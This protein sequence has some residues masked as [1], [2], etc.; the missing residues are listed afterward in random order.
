MATT[1]GDLVTFCEHGGWLGRDATS[2]AQLRLWIDDTIQWLGRVRRWPDYEESTYI[3]LLAPY[4]TGT[5]TVTEASTTVLGESP[6]DVTD[7]M[8]GQEFYCA[9]E[10]GKLYQ[11]AS[12]SSGANTLTLEN[13]YTGD[14]G[15]EQDF[16][17]R[18]VRYAAPTDWGQAGVLYLPDGRELT[19]SNLSFHDW[20]QARITH[21]GTASWPSDIVYQK[22]SG[23]GYFF[24]HP[25]PSAASSVR[26]TYWAAPAALTSDSDVTDWPDDLMSLLHTVLKK[27]M[28]TDLP[29]PTFFSMMASELRDDLDAAMRSR[30]ALGPMQIHPPGVEGGIGP[31]LQSIRALFNFPDA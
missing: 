26:G 14:D 15:S 11:I 7:A 17:I 28:S 12:V 31:G 16:S 23:T 24:V 30:G 6:M 21:Q 9:D 2:V 10:P 1:L 8:A 25:A 3:D 4:T 29:N 13:A 5:V 22:V 18:Y 27:R 20:H 19:A